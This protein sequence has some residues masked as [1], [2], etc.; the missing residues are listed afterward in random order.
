MKYYSDNESVQLAFDKV[1]KRV[2]IYIITLIILMFNYGAA[3]ITFDFHPGLAFLFT[4]LTWIPLMLK[5]STNWYNESI[6][7]LTDPQEFYERSLRLG[8][9][10]EWQA[11]RSIKINEIEL[12]ERLNRPPD[13][14]PYK[15]LGNDFI[16][17][18]N[19]IFFK[20]QNYSWDEIKNFSISLRAPGGQHQWA[21][22]HFFDNK[23][24][25]VYIKTKEIFKVEYLIDKYLNNSRLKSTNRK[26]YSQ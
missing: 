19:F 3:A 13:N 18:N 22:F 21:T 9:V 14:L 20:K 17:K 7:S 10:F 11:N 6:K 12:K 23:E 16:L 26:Q 2:I 15:V 8:L 4:V 25:S 5:I 24:I 1:K